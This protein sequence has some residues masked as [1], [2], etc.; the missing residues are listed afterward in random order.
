MPE[1]EITEEQLE[2]EEAQ[3]TQT[4]QQR[5]Q[6]FYRQSGGPGN[7]AI[8]KVLDRHLRYGADH[9]VSGHMETVEDAFRDVVRGDK[10]LMTLYQL[11]MRRQADK[12]EKEEQRKDD[13]AELSEK[14]GRMEVEL[15]EKVGRLEGE[16][17]SLRELLAQVLQPS[18]ELKK[19]AGK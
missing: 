7:P 2:A 8:K 17:R 12:E 5:I 18:A 3:E 9:G 4:M 11:Y 14:V 16:L 19:E 6:V 10:S 15:S 13:L 1:Y